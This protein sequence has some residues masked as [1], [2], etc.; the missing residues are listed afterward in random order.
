MSR[1]YI[2][3]EFFV[4]KPKHSSIKQIKEEIKKEAR[5]KANLKEEP[6]FSVSD[7]PA[8]GL[9]FVETPNAN[10]KRTLDEIRKKANLTELKELEA[11]TGISEIG[12]DRLHKKEE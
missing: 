8:P 12:I 9:K 5:R 2:L 11:K 4:E 10:C 1:P 7:K 6:D 3:N